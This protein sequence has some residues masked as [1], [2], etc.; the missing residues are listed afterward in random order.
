MEGD[1]CSGMPCYGLAIDILQQAINRPSSWEGASFKEA[2]QHASAHPAQAVVGH[3]QEPLLL[4]AAFLAFFAG[5]IVYVRCDF[6]LLPA[7]KTKLL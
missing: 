1:L 3:A 6:A 4:V 2:A 5:I 7:Q